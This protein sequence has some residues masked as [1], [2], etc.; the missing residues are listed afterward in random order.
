M[1]IEQLFVLLIAKGGFSKEESRFI[2]AYRYNGSAG[3]QR[4][5]SGVNVFARSLDGLSQET[6][7]LYHIRSISDLIDS[8][9]IARISGGPNQRLVSPFRSTGSEESLDLLLDRLTLTAADVL[10]G[11]ININ[12]ASVTVLQMIPFMTQTMAER[13]IQAR[14]KR[15]AR[16]DGVAWLL[17]DNVLTLKEFR[18]IEPFI[19]G[20][21]HIFR[22]VST[23]YDD[24]RRIRENKSVVV[25]VRWGQPQFRYFAD[26]KF[27]SVVIPGAAHGAGPVN[28]NVPSGN[29]N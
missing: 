7:P 22:F 19:T 9:V 5:P 23:G 24:V 1:N 28:S 4:I 2:A 10:R 16:S 29:T 8:E 15:T 21:G 26:I 13:I 6:P 11:R 14:A 18:G 17:T 3:T 27:R 20:K 12:A 25:D